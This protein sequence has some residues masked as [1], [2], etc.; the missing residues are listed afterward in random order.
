MYL[1]GRIRRNLRAYHNR[2][3]QPTD[4]HNHSENAG[5]S[6]EGSSEPGFK[7]FGNTSL[8]GERMFEE[9]FTLFSTNRRVFG[10]STSRTSRTSNHA[11]KDFSDL[12]DDDD[13]SHTEPRSAYSTSHG[14]SIVRHNHQR[15]NNR[16]QS[17]TS[18]NRQL[19]NNRRRNNSFRPTN[20][21]QSSAKHLEHIGDPLERVHARQSLPKLNISMQE[22]ASHQTTE[23]YEDFKDFEVNF[24]HRP[25]IPISKMLTPMID[26][27]LISW[28]LSLN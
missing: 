7:S 8:P 13:E 1:I 12:A 5:S 4:E 20:H 11:P 23:D 6:L 2:R 21:D 27:H 14:P 17:R 10:T 15:Q 22:Q 9:T 25:T 24:R 18:I 19:M 26:R 16:G 28:K 3:N